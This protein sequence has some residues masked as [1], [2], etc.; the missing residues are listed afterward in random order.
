MKYYSYEEFAKDARA[1]SLEA[2]TLG[3]DGFVGI[4]RGG[5]TLAH[6]LCEGADSKNMYTIKASSYHGQDKEGKPVISKIPELGNEKVVAIVDEIVDSGDTMKRVLEE[7]R[8]VYPD[9]K[10]VA[11]TIFQKPSAIIKADVYAHETDEWIDFFWEADM[12][13]TKNV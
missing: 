9:K 8:A 1:L 3:V 13:G 12:R 7:F 2:V 5:A 6:F 10:F 4:L 11:F